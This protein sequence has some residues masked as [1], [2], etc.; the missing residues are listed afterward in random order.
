LLYCFAGCPVED[1][2]RALGIELADLFP[3]RERNDRPIAFPKR[4]RPATLPRSVAEI[5]VAT[6]EFA[7]AWELAKLLATEEPELG[8][9]DLLAS[10]KRLE[11]NFDIPSVLRLAY[12]LRGVAMFRYMNA[13]S[14][15]DAT[16]VNRAVRRLCGEVEHG[17]SRAA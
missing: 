14:A 12:L 11:H 5:L 6:S 1:I 15:G 13:R 17:R 10:W 7:E 4:E 8:W 9:Q 3:P 16:A 2:A